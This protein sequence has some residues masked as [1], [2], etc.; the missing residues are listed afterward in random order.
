MLKDSTD[1]LT[2][3]IHTLDARF[4]KLEGKI[5]AK[6]D[7]RIDTL[8]AEFKSD[9]KKV[10]NKVDRLSSDMNKAKGAADAYAG[11]LRSANAPTH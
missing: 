9:L 10:S 1:E 7:A 3:K 5:D 11:L 2:A 6:L 4:D 8:R